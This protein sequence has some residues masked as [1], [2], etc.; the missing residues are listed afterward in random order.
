MKL[1]QTSGNGIDLSRS[2]SNGE[3]KESC[4]TGF[5]DSHKSSCTSLRYCLIFSSEALGLHNPESD[6]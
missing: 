1:V 6:N 3:E 5:V 2:V 4:V